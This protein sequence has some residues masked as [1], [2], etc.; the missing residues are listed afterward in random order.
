MQRLGV[1]IEYSLLF[2]NEQTNEKAKLNIKT[3][4][5]KLRSRETD[6]MNKFIVANRI[7]IQ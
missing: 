3:L 1:S 5:L 7:C 4:S 6:E 2:S